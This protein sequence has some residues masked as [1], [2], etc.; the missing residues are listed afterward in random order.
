MD[1]LG[2][3]LQ[4]NSKTYVEKQKNLINKNNI[5]NSRVGQITLPESKTSWA[6]L[7]ETRG[8]GDKLET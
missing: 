8:T 6:A 1:L 5:E 3:N 2:R 7:V 4:T